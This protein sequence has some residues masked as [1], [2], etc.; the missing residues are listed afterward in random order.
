MFFLFNY[1]LFLIYSLCLPSNYLY[2]IHDLVHINNR[3]FIHHI[4]HYWEEYN[5]IHKLVVNLLDLYYLSVD[6]LQINLLL[7]LKLFDFKEEYYLVII[8]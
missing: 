2:Q 6:S 1:L 8:N 3:Y 5:L 7:V 4:L